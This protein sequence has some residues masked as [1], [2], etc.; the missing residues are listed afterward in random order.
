MFSIPWD[1]K[2][3]THYSKRAG[4]EVSGVVAVLC[5]NIAG[6]HQLIAAKKLNLFNQIKKKRK[7]GHFRVTLSLSF[8]E[9]KCEI[10]VMVI[11]SNFNMN[12]N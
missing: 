2:E 4:H 11:S 7:K 8:K 1:V 10:V 3:P 9:S 12:E 5:K 6:P